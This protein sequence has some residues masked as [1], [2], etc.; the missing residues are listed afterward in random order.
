MKN[1]KRSIPPKTDGFALIEAMI[2]LGILISL[3]AG[4]TAIVSFASHQTSSARLTTTN[5]RLAQTLYRLAGT[6]AALRASA[7]ADPKLEPY[8]NYFTVCLNGGD[9]TQ[10][11]VNKNL[12]KDGHSHYYPFRLYLAT[13]VNTVSSSNGYGLK[14][15]GA[16]TGTEKFPIR[17]D[18]NG[19]SCDTSL[20]LCPEDKYPM[21]AF[22]EFLPICFDSWTSYWHDFGD[23]K[24]AEPIYPNAFIP[25]DTCW[26]AH[27]MKIRVTVRA[28][29]AP[30]G[31]GAR[32]TVI[33]NLT[34]DAFLAHFNRS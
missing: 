16:V 26:C 7:A 13:V 4:S 2:A 34:I 14:T 18:A 33:M 20:G 3:F 5:Q 29:A 9:G 25:H 21:E 17:Y 23:P 28:S 24:P 22:T 1:T 11:C 19:E 30:T 15:S 8:N 32:P 31:G 10:P 12:D 27:F 6:P